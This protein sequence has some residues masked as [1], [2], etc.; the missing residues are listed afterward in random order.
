[1]TEIGRILLVTGAVM[2]LVGL[3]LMLGGRLPGLG[4]LPLDFHWQ[5]GNTRL[6][7]PL[8]TMLLISLLLTL[9]LNFVARWFR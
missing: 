4:R 6:Y 2:A 1:M 7:F 3:L 9:V 5:F 8:G